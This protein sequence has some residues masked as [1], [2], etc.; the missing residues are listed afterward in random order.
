MLNFIFG[1]AATGKTYE[2]MQRLKKDVEDGK[3]VVLLVPE[4][5]SFESEREVLLTLGD[6]SSTLVNVLN[7]TRMCDE[8]NRLAGGNAFSVMS[9]CDKIISM[10]TA[11][12]AVKD[13]LVIW[14]KYCNS[15]RFAKVMLSAIDELKASSIKTEDLFLANAPSALGVKLSDLYKI[16][17]T[18]D[19]MIH[20]RFID[21][22]DKLTHL[23]NKLSQ[24]RYFEGK[25]VYIDSFKEFSGQQ[26][27]IL[28]QIFSQCNNVTVSLLSNGDFS[29]KPDN[30]L[31]L[32]KLYFR[33][34][35]IAKKFGVKIGEE[36]ILKDSRYNSKELAILEKVLAGESLN[37][38]YKTEDITIFNASWIYGEADFVM[39]TIRRLSREQGYRFRDF[40]VIAR[41]FK[42]YE[43][44]IVN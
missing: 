5:F 43:K 31:C 12:K 22:A 18:Y 42:T 21:P 1:R 30:F 32:K 28:E 19:A 40:V 7:F 15:P 14:K 34:K 41:D 4:Q 11:L 33:L 8:V 37:H 24:F 6:N 26:Y 9:E 44:A 25:E 23:Y 35:N 10:R 20:N 38:E 2:I 29:D 27:K 36:K 16:Y 17:S 39:R 3:D 13:E